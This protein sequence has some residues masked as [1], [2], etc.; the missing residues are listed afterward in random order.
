MEERDLCFAELTRVASLVASRALSPVDLTRAVLER[1]RR[2]D[3]SLH[4]YVTVLEDEALRRAAWCEAR[5]EA[6]EPLGPLHGVP[7]AVK[8]LCEMVDTPTTCASPVFAERVTRCDATVVARLLA[9]GA[10]VVGK[11]NMTEFAYA[12]Y[13]PALE[14]ARNPWATDRW[15]GLSS[16]GS[17]AATAAGM[18]FAAIGTDTG[19][20]IRYPSA[21]NGVVGIKPTYGQVSRFGVFPLSDTLDHVGPMARTV[22]DAATVLDVIGGRD[23]RDPSTAHAVTGACL[24]RIDA[25]AAGLV[26]GVDEPYCRGEAGELDEEVGTAFFAALARL[27]RLGATIRPVRIDMFGEALGAWFT[28]FAVDAALVH[29]DLFAT[30][31]DRYGPAFR[32]LL[33]AAA[34]MQAIYYAEARAKRRAIRHRLQALFDGVDAIACPALARPAAPVGDRTN[35]AHHTLGSH[36]FTIPYDL[37]GNP[38]ITLPCGFSEDGMPLAMQLVGRWH[39]EA[40]ICQLAHAYERDTDWHQR[41]PILPSEVAGDGSP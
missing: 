22:R 30:S 24:S 31:A 21:A 32:E 5:V 16:S 2:H 8:D 41:H 4:A 23:E 39:D 33:D 36:S 12:G 25:G 15:A 14:A 11:L 13:H 3:G 9:A 26:I 37:A 17:G 10:I 20:S 38:T 27:E 34:G 1:I 35:E 18:C 28:I 29:R 40:T 6:G 7:L 19:G